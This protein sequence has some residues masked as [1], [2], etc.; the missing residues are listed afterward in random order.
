MG[1]SY[2]IEKGTG[3]INLFRLFVEVSDNILV[4]KMKKSELNDNTVGPP[5][6]ENID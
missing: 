2:I 6:T 4:G 1:K 3:Y 5:Y